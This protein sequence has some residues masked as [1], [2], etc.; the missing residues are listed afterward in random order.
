MPATRF[1]RLS[2]FRL[3]VND[4]PRSERATRSLELPLVSDEEPVLLR[5]ARLLPDLLPIV[6]VSV[7]LLRVVVVS[8]VLEPAIEP[9]RLGLELAEP[10]VVLGLVLA[11]P[12]VLLGLDVLAEPVELR[13][14]VL[15]IEPLVLLP[16]LPLGALCVLVLGP[17]VSFADGGLVFLPVSLIAPEPVVEPLLL[18]CA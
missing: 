14:V 17:G 18:V 6:L 11:V 2:L 3:L 15:L 1:F 7:L 5:D 12:D 4:Y 13:G 8:V 16:V 10:D 9:L